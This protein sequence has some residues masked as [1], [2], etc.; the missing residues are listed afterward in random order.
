[1]GYNKTPQ[2]FQPIKRNLLGEFKINRISIYNLHIPLDNF[3]EYSTSVTLAR[4]IGINPIKPF[5]SYLGALCGVFGKTDLI[6]ILDLSRKFEEAIGHNVKLYNYG[7]AKIRAGIVAVVAG[8]GLI[9][10][11][12][13]VSHNNVNLLVTGI[14]AFNSH[15]QMAHDFAKKHEINILGG[16]HYS[17]E[18]FECIAIRDYFE[19]LGLECRFI[20]GKPALED[21]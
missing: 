7:Q 3:G 16:T 15:S 18:K 5:A 1:L 2:V 21:I 14:T 17:T 12:E 10:S 13:E 8:G 11:I 20:E 9:D 19:K 6:T 4:A